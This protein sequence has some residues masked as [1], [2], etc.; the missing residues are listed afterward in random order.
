[1]TDGDA[2][3]ISTQRTSTQR[4]L[5]VRADSTC[6][7]I[8]D[9]VTLR[10]SALQELDVSAKNGHCEENDHNGS[11]AVDDFKHSEQH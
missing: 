6:A 7:M 5:L 2:I 10:A 9:S 1:M 8:D 3:W 11:R 4:E